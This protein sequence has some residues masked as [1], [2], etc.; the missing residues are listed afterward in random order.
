MYR[1]EIESRERKRDRVVK[2]E[3]KR[4]CDKKKRNENDT[5]TE[6][7]REEERKQEST[8]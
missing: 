5:K 8:L 3:G 4:V 1:K 6:K 2:I 7:E